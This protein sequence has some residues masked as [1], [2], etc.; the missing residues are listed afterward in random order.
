MTTTTMEQT[1]IV[2]TD[3]T[4]ITDKTICIAIKRGRFGTRRRANKSAMTID[5]DKSLLGLSKNILDSPELKAIQSLDVELTAYLSSR[6]LKS[7]FKGGVYLLPI[8]LVEEVDARVKSFQSRR[9]VLVEAAVAA[10][11]QR[12]TETVERLGVVGDDSQYPSV[13][14]FAASFY[15][16]YE[17]VTFSTP[18]R[19]KAI[20]PA[21]FEAERMKAQ[22]RLAQVSEQCQAAMRAG[23]AKLV[24]TMIDRLKPH[25]DGKTR[26]FH[27][28][29]VE[30]FN[31]FLQTFE[32][33]NVTDD[34]ELAGLVVKARAVLA[35]CDPEL[36]RSDIA[37]RTALTQRFE[38]I[39]EAL[40][41]MV[42]QRA[43]SFDDED[44]EGAE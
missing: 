19:L 16:E 33:R 37:S 10:Y 17:Y 6:C 20:N 14:R 40:I 28:S 18:S 9:A 30:N 25:E 22:A 5:A 3:G 42:S 36:V 27:K 11:P 1:A 43:I 39:Q 35:G 41:P 38:E 44:M 2:A 31:D 7:M 29:I 21:I 26:R 12:I 15:L 32:M 8:A 34:A 23:L 24:D 4:A 13:E